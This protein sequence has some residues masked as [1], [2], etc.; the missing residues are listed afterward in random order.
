LQRLKGGVERAVEGGLLGECP[1]E[2]HFDGGAFA[3]REGAALKLGP[4]S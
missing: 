1:C 3:A 2:F 4:L